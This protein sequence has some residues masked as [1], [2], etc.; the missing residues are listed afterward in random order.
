MRRRVIA[1]GIS[2]A[3][4][5]LVA[6]LLIDRLDR[7]VVQTAP[8]AIATTGTSSLATVPR[9]TAIEAAP[10]SMAEAIG[11]LAK[12]DLGIPVR[13]VKPTDL[14]DTFNDTRAIGRRHDAIDIMAPRGTE[15]LAA[16]DGTIEKL[17][18]SKAG[19]LTI[20]Q[21]DPTQTFSYYYAHLDRYATGLAEH[22][23][24][25]RGQRLGYVGSTGNASED[26]PHLHFAIARLD[27]DRSWWKGDP[28]NPYPLLSK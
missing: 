8:V 26:A 20:Y 10:L 17:F 28:I 11:V 14:H 2:F 4:G 18:T 6:T 9:A 12:S 13:G 23:P 24:V 25:R 27:T 1:I 21:F 3:S 19:G 15:V 16:D 5:A 22:Q 7:P